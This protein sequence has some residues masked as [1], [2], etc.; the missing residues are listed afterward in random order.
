M[1]C[2]INLPTQISLET[3][4]NGFKMVMKIFFR[5]LYESKEKQK[6]SLQDQID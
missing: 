5:Q 4:V 2:T 1:N 3:N 6:K